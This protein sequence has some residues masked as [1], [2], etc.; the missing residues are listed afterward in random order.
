MLNLNLS[1]AKSKQT[2]RLRAHIVTR[3]LHKL[4]AIG[5]YNEYPL[6]LFPCHLTKPK[7][8]RIKMKYYS[9]QVD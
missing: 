5:H 4:I 7:T 2:D 8:K 9:K 6:E 1:H 3:T